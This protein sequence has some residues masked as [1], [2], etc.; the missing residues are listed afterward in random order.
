MD[1]SHTLLVYIVI[2]VFISFVLIFI[3]AFLYL[4]GCN[5]VLPWGGMEK[6]LE[7]L[8]LKVGDVT[9]LQDLTLSL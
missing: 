4:C 2:L 5:D 9:A 6:D 3:V 8:H 7:T 1:N